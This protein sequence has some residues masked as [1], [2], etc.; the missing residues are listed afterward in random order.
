MIWE[1]V[2]ALVVALGTIA[3]L[4]AFCRG[5]TFRSNF[6]LRVGIVYGFAFAF[7]FLWEIL[8][9]KITTVE[10]AAVFIL[11]CIGV[12]FIVDTDWF[13]AS[14]TA[15]WMAMSG[16][17]FYEW[18]ALF[19]TTLREKLYRTSQL[20]LMVGIVGVCAALVVYFT[21]AKALRQGR[22]RPVGPRQSVCAVVLL[23][24]F[25]Q[26]FVTIL[27]SANTIS[28]TSG[29]LAE[30]LIQL[31]CITFLYFQDEVFKKV[32]MQK[33]LDTL[34]AMYDQK[35]RQYDLAKHNVT[36]MNQYCH[37][38]KAK[39]ASM[40][41]TLSDQESIHML[42]DLEKSV[43]LYTDI[44]HTGDDVLDMVLTEKNLLCRDQQIQINCVA[45]GKLLYFMRPA[46]V[47]TI[48][49]VA[50]GNAMQ[51][52]ATFPE[53][54]KR[55]IDISIGK[56]QNFL[57][58]NVF[59]PLFHKENV[60]DPLSQPMEEQPAY[61]LRTIKKI[62]SDYHGLMKIDIFRDTFSLNIMIPFP[63]KQ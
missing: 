11:V 3:I 51:E 25:L 20:L 45:D 16:E 44:V 49:S 24:F 10:E 61:E 8:G 55:L 40:R 33:E 29:Y 7:A 23:A 30:I 58:I 28:Q 62:V 13:D 63:Q 57:F 31:Y 18:T 15:V 14:Y 1:I 9:A 54:E 4:L 46:D 50:I 12:H 26:T 42:T 17:L 36:L 6:K 53:T 52:V 22:I 32:E 21:V 60:T 39:I 19:Y 2:G 5:L 59:N 47:Y 56:R 48:F 38:L 27:Q 41:Q 35:I 43:N 37:N 34:N